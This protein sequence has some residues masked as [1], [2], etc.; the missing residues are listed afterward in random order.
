MEGRDDRAL[1][2]VVGT[3]DFFR[4]V[5]TSEA[6]NLPSFCHVA[7][8]RKADSSPPEGGS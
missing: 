2:Y 6:K 1:L 5:I 7:M 3:W 8:L 4:I